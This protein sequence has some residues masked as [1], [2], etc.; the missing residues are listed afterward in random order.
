M[1]Q[2]CEFH[3]VGLALNDASAETLTRQI[4][5]APHMPESRTPTRSALL[6]QREP[7]SVLRTTSVR[8]MQLG[9]AAS[10]YQGHSEVSP[11][12]RSSRGIET[13][14]VG[15]RSSAATGIAT[16]I[17]H[18]APPP[19]LNAAS[20]RTEQAMHAMK[21]A[22]ASADALLLQIA[23]QADQAEA[24]DASQR[25]KRAVL[26]A[27]ARAHDLPGNKFSR[28]AQQ[29]EVPGKPA[30]SML[31]QG[32]Q[33]QSQAVTNVTL[34]SG[35]GIACSGHGLCNEARQSCACLDGWAG[36]TCDTPECPDNCNNR[37][38]CLASKC[39]CDATYFG[40]SCQHLRC[41]DD[42]SGHGYCFQ[43]RC[44]CTGDYGGKNCNEV[45]HPTGVLRLHVLAHSSSMVGLPSAAVS[46]VH[47]GIGLDCPSNCGGHGSCHTGQ[48]TCEAEWSGPNCQN[49]CPSGCSDHGDCV[50]GACLC[51]AGWS[52]PGCAQ[53]GCCNGHGSCANPDGACLCDSGWTGPSCAAQKICVDPTCSSHGVCNHGQCDCAPGFSG[54]SC[55]MPFESCFGRCG[56]HGS[57]EARTNQCLCSANFTGPH[58]EMLEQSCASGCTG[59]GDC[60]AGA[61]VCDAGWGGE[62]CSSAVDLSTPSNATVNNAGGPMSASLLTLLN[63]ANSVKQPPQASGSL[64][65][66]AAS[67]V[68]HVVAKPAAAVTTSKS[69][70]SLLGIAASLGS[71]SAAQASTPGTPPKS[72]EW[73]HLAASGGRAAAVLAQSQTP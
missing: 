3:D 38:M 35:C 27:R 14:V 19:L 44:Q 65:S 66:D 37:G 72:M 5:G 67:S 48:C 10:S 45:V 52:G 40:A 20:T 6:Q 51:L 8:N 68:A 33:R 71:S 63:A 58:C 29:S 47:S 17:A 13:A 42:C 46:T 18:S 31:E 69:L 56:P 73:L 41:P 50:A 24:L 53:M 43:G 25:I 36:A 2:H 22:R 39:M 1:G 12:I 55:L 11:G 60:V 64:S 21:I 26:R 23:G 57:C 49:H 61:C 32:A 9:A 30:L 28:I 59:H 62:D 7:S 16:P 70:E 4:V 54:I 15:S 34:G